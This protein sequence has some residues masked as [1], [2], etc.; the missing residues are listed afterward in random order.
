MLGIGIVGYIT[1]QAFLNIGAITGLLPLTGVPLPFFSY[2]SSALIVT[3][4]SVG[5]ML[6]ISKQS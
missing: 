1:I 5:I 6:N 2:G 4:A 3:L